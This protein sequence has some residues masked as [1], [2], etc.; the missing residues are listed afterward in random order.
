MWQPPSPFKQGRY[1]YTGSL[2]HWAA[3][4]EATQEWV[5][6]L[7]P[8]LRALFAPDQYT[9]VD[10]AIRHELDGHQ[11]AQWL[12]GFYA[13]HA[14]PYPVRIETL[15]RLCG[16]E[17]GETW[18]YAQTLRGAL[19]AVVAASAKHGE[20]FSY[21]IR[22]DLVHVTK[23]ASR[24]QQRHLIREAIKSTIQSGGLAPDIPS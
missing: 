19:D 3:K 2:I 23:R 4:D 17:A 14:E 1:T 18:K 7:D 21:E 8:R 13:S 10:W 6:E 20:Q 5:I 24:S 9:L 15:H 16:S 22:G 12:H 11:L